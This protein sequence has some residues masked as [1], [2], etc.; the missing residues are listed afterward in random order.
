[1]L[2]TLELRY[3]VLSPRHFTEKVIPALYAET[4]AKVED[5]PA[6]AGLKGPPNPL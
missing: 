6:M 2:A 4:R 1:M 5:G 3:E